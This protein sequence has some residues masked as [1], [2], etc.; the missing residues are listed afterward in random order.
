MSL[1]KNFSNFSSLL[2]LKNKM[3][4][5]LN[6]FDVLRP[7][8]KLP[9]PVVEA[10]TPQDTIRDVK[11]VASANFND[12]FNDGV[13]HQE[14]FGPEAFRQRDV[15][16]EFVI[17]AK[18]AEEMFV[19][20]ENGVY[21]TE[22]QEYIA[23]GGSLEELM[24]DLRKYDE[25]EVEIRK[26][27]NEVDKKLAESRREYVR[28]V[29]AS[30]KG[31][32]INSSE[33]KDQLKKS[34]ELYMEAVLGKLKM[35]TESR[36]EDA[37][38]IGQYRQILERISFGPDIR[39]SLE[40]LAGNHMHVLVDLLLREQLARSMLIEQMSDTG[41]KKVL[42]GIKNNS[43]VK[44][45]VVGS[46]FAG[47]ALSMASGR[48]PSGIDNVGEVAGDGLKWI[49]AYLSSRSLIGSAN[50][51]I[52]NL[53][54]KRHFKKTKEELAGDPELADLTMRTAYGYLEHRDTELRQGSTDSNENKE[55]FSNIANYLVDMQ[56]APGGRPY[57][58]ENLFGYCE[59]LYLEK[60]DDLE[61]I[62]A[63]EDQGQAYFDFASQILAE[64]LAEMSQDLTF[65]KVKRG[66]YRGVSAIAAT[67]GSRFVSGAGRLKNELITTPA[68]LTKDILNDFATAGR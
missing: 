67:I 65:G 16:A 35:I 18:I 38:D 34:E 19:G 44:A 62:A 15:H 45:A 28:K 54:E 46:V 63:G 42:N 49:A 23:R 57:K 24:S 33:E 60:K 3:S 30:K 36:P 27:L 66:V 14:V 39:H 58:S 26:P 52:A 32:G 22:A 56:T 6:S 64:D 13:A 4:N 9:S 41:I 31:I 43:K 17:K 50:Q 8:S 51:G 1:T 21:S 53:V 47:S 48:L 5:E 25:G 20:G 40:D 12:R 7:V 55:R 68:T 2:T 61:A 59:R 11:A 29:M 37:K 10:K